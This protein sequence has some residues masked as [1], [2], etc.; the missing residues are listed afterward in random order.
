MIPEAVRLPSRCPPPEGARRR[1]EVLP[2]P[3]L[4]LPEAAAG[5]W[6]LTLAPPPG[7]EGAPPTTPGPLAGAVSV[8][9]GG[10][11]G[12]G[13]RLALL[14]PLLLVVGL[15]LWELTAALFPR[16]L[17]DADVKQAAAAL[18]AE[19]RAGDL[20]ATAPP[21]IAP[22]VQREL[23]DL[24]PASLVGRADAARFGRIFEVSFAD[25][26]SA[27]TLGLTPDSQRRFGRLVLARYPHQP[28]AV[29]FDL[30][31]QLMAAQVTFGRTGGPAAAQVAAS[32]GEQPCLFSGPPPGPQPPR[33]PA[34][35]FR[36][37]RGTVEQRTAEVDYQPRRAVVVEAAEGG[38]TA[39]TWTGISDD[40][41]RGGRLVLWLGHHDFHRRKT[42]KGPSEVV[43]D[44]D[45]GA[46]RV[47]LWVEVHQPFLST[48]IPLPA[49]AVGARHSLRIEVAAQSATNHLV[50]LH[51]EIRR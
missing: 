47:V 35:A 10:G 19:F 27:D 24:M 48:E 3:V 50:A 11:R 20:I 2:W 49:G 21:W 40:D 30:T 38:R 45:R 33:G 31:E 22:L 28:V 9:R 25:Q 42:A 26:R 18:R 1:V 32:A 17:P 23:G 46:A 7:E 5:L 44:L 6:T 36:C 12:P 29:T 14:G 43:V 13:P 8:D 15:A 51:G 34:G 39:L 41:W 4:A 16:T 37:E